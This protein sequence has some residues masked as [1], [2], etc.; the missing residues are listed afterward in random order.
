MLLGYHPAV[1]GDRDEQVTLFR[2][3]LHR[4]HGKSVHMRFQGLHGIHFRYDHSGTESFRAHRHAFSTPAV[5]GDHDFLP[6]DDQ[7]RRTVDPI[8]NGLAGTVAV[9]EQMLAVRIVDRDHRKMQLTVLFHFSKPCYTR[10]RLFAASDDFFL[11]TREL[12][13]D[14]MHD[15]AA[16]VYDDIRLRL[17]HA[18]DI[19]VIFFLCAAVSR[20]NMH[21]QSVKFRRD[22]VLR[23]QRIASGRVNFR[24][25]CGESLAETGGLRL[26]MYGKR[27]L[28]ACQRSL[29]FEIFAHR[30]EQGHVVPYPGDLVCSGRSKGTVPDNACA[31]HAASSA[32]FISI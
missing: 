18:P 23:G 21:A 11:K 27:H 15:I 24:S 29:F 19:Q 7:I 10:G 26:K 31:A 9:V 17:Y 32:P 2:R 4:H 3:F 14:H 25:A 22:V 20:V 5:S 28:Q 16:V 12:R 1:A 30:P 8:E 6:R 13:A